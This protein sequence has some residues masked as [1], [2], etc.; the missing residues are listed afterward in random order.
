VTVGSR[1]GRS[2]YAGTLA[3]GSGAGRE[4][5]DDGDLHADGPP[6]TQAPAISNLQ[7]HTV[8]PE[9]AGV[10]PACRDRA[11]F[12]ETQEVFERED[13]A[14][15]QAAEQSASD[16]QLEWAT[17]DVLRQPDGQGPGRVRRR[18]PNMTN[19]TEHGVISAGQRAGRC[20]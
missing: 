10:T 2:L 9:L 13:L 6:M 20:S 7:P 14:V 4:R 16:S 17:A 12:Y 5:L 1:H 11:G 8:G 15:A 3:S 18:A 19:A